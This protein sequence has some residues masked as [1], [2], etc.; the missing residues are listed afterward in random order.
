MHSAGFSDGNA[1]RV[2]ALFLGHLQAWVNN[3]TPPD[4]P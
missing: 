3:N 1:A 2:F 4:R